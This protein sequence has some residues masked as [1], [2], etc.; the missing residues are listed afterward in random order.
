MSAWSSST[1]ATT[2]QRCP[3]TAPESWWMRSV[4]D[5]KSAASGSKPDAS[6]MGMWMLIS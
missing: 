6:A 5:A 3:R 4:A 2:P 1:D